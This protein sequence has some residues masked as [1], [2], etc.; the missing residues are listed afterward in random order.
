MIEG[1]SSAGDEEIINA[2]DYECDPLVCEHEAKDLE[3]VVAVEKVEDVCIAETDVVEAED[4]GAD[5][6]SEE[7]YREEDFSRNVEKLRTQAETFSENAGFECLEKYFSG[8]ADVVHF[9]ENAADD[10]FAQIVEADLDGDFFENVEAVNFT[11][12]VEGVVY[13]EEDVS[14]RGEK[15][16]DEAENAGFECL[17]KYFSG[18]VNAER[19]EVER[20]DGRLYEDLE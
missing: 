5:D 2:E 16:G 15:L 8:E 11:E 3:K 13:C 19:V 1:D 12:K 18:E 6:Y 4:V 9:S 14:W 7:Y 20:F 17:D 10:S